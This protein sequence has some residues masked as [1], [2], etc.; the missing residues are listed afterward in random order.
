MSVINTKSGS[1]CDLDTIKFVVVVVV[2]VVVI[3]VLL[4]R[5]SRQ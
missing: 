2:V 5:F 3:V 4:D 1:I